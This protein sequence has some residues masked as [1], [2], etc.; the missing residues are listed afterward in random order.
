MSDKNKKKDKK[1]SQSPKV[2]SEL[3]G[4]NIEVNSFGEIVSTHKIDELRAFLDKN[5]VDKKLKDR[6]DLDVKREEDD[7]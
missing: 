7:D 5:V 4:F 6:E 2:H 3:D 1:D